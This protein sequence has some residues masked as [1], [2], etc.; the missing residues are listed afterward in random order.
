MH[1]EQIDEANKDKEREK[2]KLRKALKDKM[3]VKGVVNNDKFITNNNDGKD[4]QV[5][6]KSIG[7]FRDNCAAD[8][9]GNIDKSVQ[10]DDNLNDVQQNIT[11]E[12]DVNDVKSIQN[13]DIRNLNGD[14]ISSGSYDAMIDESI[15]DNIETSITTI[16]S[17]NDVVTELLDNPDTVTTTGKIAEDTDVPVGQRT[18]SPSFLSDPAY[19][20]IG[21]DF[22]V[23]IVLYC[24]VLYCIVLYCIVLYCIVL[25]CIVLYC[26]VSYCIVLYCIVLYCIV[27]YCIVLYCIVLYCIVLY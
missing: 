13:N 14:L 1:Q 18:S 15:L 12:M 7:E 17:T 20:L 23:C 3:K 24:I 5:D 16:K 27:L 22:G 21:R 19:A 6:L 4:I 9:V 8:E 2:S 11:E 26:I 10:D 25:Y